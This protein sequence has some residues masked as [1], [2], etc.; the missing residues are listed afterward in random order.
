MAYWFDVIFITIDLP[1]A[2]DVKL[3]LGPEDKFYFST[4]AGTDNVPYEIDFNFQ[5]KV[6]VNVSTVVNLLP[7]ILTTSIQTTTIWTTTT[8]PFGL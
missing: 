1:D 7:P 6:D 3:K 5:D 4:T 2:K 8:P